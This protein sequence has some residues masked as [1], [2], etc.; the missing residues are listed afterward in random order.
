VGQEEQDKK[1]P[2]LGDWA[3]DFT[4]RDSTGEKKVTLSDFRDQRPV[5]LVFGSFT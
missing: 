1:A 4:L 2:K 5:V 3:P